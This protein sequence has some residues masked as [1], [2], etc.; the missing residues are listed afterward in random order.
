MPNPIGIDQANF[1][2]NQDNDSNESPLLQVLR[3]Y[4]LGMLKACG[5][6]NERVKSEHSY[7]VCTINTARIEII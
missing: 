5:Y 1:V 7:E 4:C 2:R 6:V 3:A